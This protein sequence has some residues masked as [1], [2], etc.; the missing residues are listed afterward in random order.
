[1]SLKNAKG[2]FIV[3]YDSNR[4]ITFTVHKPKRVHIKF[5]MHRDRLHY[6]DTVNRQ[7]T[8]VQTVTDNDK[9]YSQRQLV[10]AKKARDLYAKVGYPLIRDFVV[11]IKK[12][13]INN[14]PVT[15]EDVIR[16]ERINGPSVQAFKGKIIRTKTSPVVTYYVAVPYAI[17]EENRNFTLSVDVMFVNRI[18]FLTSIIC[19]LKFTTAETFHNRITSQLV[20]CVTNVKALYTKRGFNVS[21]ALMDV[22]FVR[23]RTSLLKMG[24]SLNTASASEHVPEI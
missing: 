3:T 23:M 13:M 1:M 8:M 9:G 11:M 12:N 2:K 4:D 16:A 20:K 5:G 18:P 17:F 19:H 7:V 24:V 14:C 6:H 22:E 15:V 10:N 21:K